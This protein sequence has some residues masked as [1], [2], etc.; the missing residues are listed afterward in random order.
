MQTNPNG[1]VHVWDPVVRIGHWVLVIAFFTAYFTED[2]FLTQHVWA[3]YVVGGYVCLRLVWGFVG[4]KHARFSDFLQ[5]PG[6]TMAYLRDLVRR[7]SVRYVGHNP[8][9]AAMVIALLLSLSG[10]VYTGLVLY[11]VEENAGPLADMIASEEG[12]SSATFSMFS[13]A[14]AD[15]ERDDINE[16]AE[17][18]WEE[19]HE[20]FSNFT[21]LLV[22]IHIAGVLFSSYVH[23]ENL[24][25]A[26]FTGQK[27]RE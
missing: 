7:R 18:F 22:G 9:G 17:E 24:V 20:L 10:T 3:G 25:K 2:E 23:K 8:A 13:L 6:H 11:A 1:N 16:E 4:T 27:R 26:M 5:T 21:L 19:L 15:R 12:H 14:H